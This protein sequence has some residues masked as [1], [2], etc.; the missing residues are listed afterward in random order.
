MVPLK[1]VCFNFRIFYRD[2]LHAQKFQKLITLLFE[3]MWV[4]KLIG[5]L[6]KGRESLL[7]NFSFLR[8][9]TTKLGPHM[10]MVKSSEV[11]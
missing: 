6:S 5:G 10:I 2:S 8:H 3:S 11:S 1:E 4:S 7:M 9:E